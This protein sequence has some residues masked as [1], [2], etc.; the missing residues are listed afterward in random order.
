V[1]MKMPASCFSVAIIYFNCDI[2]LA[3]KKPSLYDVTNS[4]FLLST[5]LYYGFFFGWS[6]CQMTSLFRDMG[7][8]MRQGFSQKNA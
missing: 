8:D 2:F 4:Q 3:K 1:H 6:S 7:L 5:C